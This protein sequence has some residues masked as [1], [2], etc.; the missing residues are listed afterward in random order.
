M[1]QRTQLLFLI[2]N[3]YLLV[4]WSLTTY[5]SFGT[6]IWADNSTNL[7]TRLTV[8]FFK[9]GF[10]TLEKKVLKRWKF[11]MSININKSIEYWIFRK[12]NLFLDTR[13]TQPSPSCLL[14]NSTTNKRNIY[15]NH[16][17]I[18][19]IFLHRKPGRVL[20]FKHLTLILNFW[21]QWNRTH[22]FALKLLLDTHEFALLY[23]YNMYI[24]KIYQ[25]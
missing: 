6:P 19:N 4:C 13:H 10:L 20:L 1:N 18:S 12:T 14:L 22:K 24:F 23:F 8:S 21:S 3:T 2:R 9:R 16:F 7:L 25:L 15:Y 11:F 5:K 17:L